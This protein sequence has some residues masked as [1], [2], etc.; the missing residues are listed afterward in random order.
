MKNQEKLFNEIHNEHFGNLEFF[1]NLKSM[2]LKKL[3][4]IKSSSYRFLIKFDLFVENI[5]QNRFCLSVLIRI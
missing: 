4:F 5:I 1:L 3:K 2:L